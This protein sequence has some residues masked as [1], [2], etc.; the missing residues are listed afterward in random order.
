MN[1]ATPQM[2]SLARQ[3]ITFDA[4]KTQPAAAASRGAFRIIDSLRPHLATLMGEGGF[5]ALLSRALVLA[6]AEVPSLSGIS[7]DAN[8]SLEATDAPNSQLSSAEFS[9]NGIV[10]VAQLLGLLAA[11]IGPTLVSQIVGEVWPQFPLGDRDFGK[12]ARSEEAN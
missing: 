2:R 10:L 7:M 1:R 6:K 5:R 4:S 12:E 8:G 3:L 11:F 9:D